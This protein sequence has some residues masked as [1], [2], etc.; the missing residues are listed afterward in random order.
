[1]KKYDVFI[2]YAIED[3][4]TVA[5]PLTNEL[6]QKGLDVY[7]AGNELKSGE[8][9]THAIYEGLEQSEYYILILSPD[10]QRKWT[11][12]ESTDIIWREKKS[13][14]KLILPVWHRIDMT[15]VERKFP[16]LSDHYA[17]KTA[18]GIS[19]VASNLY[20]EICRQKRIHLWQRVRKGLLVAFVA[21]L[22]VFSGWQ[23]FHESSGLPSEQELVRIIDE[24]IS[25]QNMAINN[26]LL[27]QQAEAEIVP[28][29]TVTKIYE[30]FKS[31]STSS[32][33][34][35][36]FTNGPEKIYGHDKL[37]SIGLVLPESPYGCFG[38]DSPRIWKLRDPKTSTDLQLFIA[39]EDTVATGFRI[40]SVFRSDA[41]SSVHAWVSYTHNI[42]VVYY[43]LTYMPVSEKMKQRVRFEGFKPREEYVVDN[44]SGIWQLREIKPS[45]Q[46]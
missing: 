39:F 28:L 10:Y 20:T 2:S 43:E 8:S 5:A 42:R 41:D 25:K 38:V 31:I 7:L 18:D 9:I 1:M 16:Q 46:K 13:K 3:K 4:Q 15:E 27:A 22:L 44:Y 34:Y 21:S 45:F 36:H 6:Q 29:D 32:P 17:E 37:K 24:R 33:N 23:F 30:H 12:V 35:Y 19:L 26:K 40:D 14:R 11:I